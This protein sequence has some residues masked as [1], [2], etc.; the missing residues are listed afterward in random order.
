MPLLEGRADDLKSA[1]RRV[2][3][4]AGFEVDDLDEVFGKPISGDL[5]AKRDGKRWLVEVT[6]SPND[7][8]HGETTKL[9]QHVDRWPFMRMDEPI[10]H[11]CLV[12]NNRMSEHVE[13]RPDEPYRDE[14]FVK[15]LTVAVC[16]TKLLY[17]WWRDQAWDKIRAAIMDPPGQ[18][19]RK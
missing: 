17:L 4:D 8:S 18:R 15:A 1:V 2:L 3:S 7:P 13:H 16:S 10:Q 11:G 5:L 9:E 14:S 12:I 19:S 6:S